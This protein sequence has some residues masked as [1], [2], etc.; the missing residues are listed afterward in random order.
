MERF[1]VVPTIALLFTSQ[2]WHARLAS[3]HYVLSM[4]FILIKM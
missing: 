1:E 3:K 4:K 2:R